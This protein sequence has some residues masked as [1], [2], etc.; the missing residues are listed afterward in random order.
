MEI[1]E[2]KFDDEELIMLLRH[3]FGSDLHYREHNQHFHRAPT[4]TFFVATI[5]DKV[6]GYCSLR[7]KMVGDVS[8]IVEFRGKGIATGM[9][10]YLQKKE[11]VLTT[12][13]SNEALRRI[14]ERLGFEFSHHRGKY[15]YYKWEAK[16]AIR[17]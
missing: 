8:T 13:T 11:V 3:H 12:G 15:K 17:G 7:G 9:V 6:V 1:K 4:K 16:D 2:Y 10:E 5:G 14:V